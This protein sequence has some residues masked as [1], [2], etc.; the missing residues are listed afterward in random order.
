MSQPLYT[1]S[2]SALDIAAMDD[3][4]SP[5]SSTLSV[6]DSTNGTDMPM[7]DH[8]DDTS[9]FSSTDAT[10]NTNST[11][12]STAARLPAYREDSIRGSMS[13]TASRPML[14]PATERTLSM[15]SAADSV[16]S[17]DSAAS[18]SAASA[19][20]TAA[21]APPLQQ[22]KRR[23]KKSAAEKAEMEKNRESREGGDKDKDTSDGGD[24]SN[25][26]T[27]TNAAGKVI[28]RRAARACVS[29]RNRKVRCDVVETFPCGNCRWDKIECVVQEGRRRRRGLFN[30][31]ESAGP[32]PG[33]EAFQHH[34]VD[35]NGHGINSINS[36]NLNGLNGQFNSAFADPKSTLGQL[37]GSGVNGANGN[38]GANGTNGASFGFPAQQRI[39]NNPLLLPKATPG[40]NLDQSHSRSHNHNHSLNHNHHNHTHNGHDHTH[41]HNGHAHS[42]NGHN[43]STAA[44]PISIAAVASTPLN[45]PGFPLLPI[46]GQLGDPQQQVAAL[47]P[48]FIR[49]LPGKMAPEDI[50]YLHSKGA[51]TLPDITLQRALLHAYV[52]FVHPYMPLLELH[53]LLETIHDRDGKHG[54]IS[55][56]LYHAVMFAAASFV[57]AKFL[58]AA[59]FSRRREA[60][61][62]F[63]MKA[64]ALYDFDYETDRLTLVQA[65]LLMTYWY[66]TP[67]DQ[68]D[69]WHWMGVAVSLAHTIGLHRDPRTTG[70]P[71]RRQR[72]RKLLWWCCFMRDRMIA[73]GMRRP[74]RIRSEDADVPMLVPGDFDKAILPD[75]IDILPAECRL[76]R[77]LDMQQQLAELCV[78]KAKLCVLVGNML[79]QQ[80]TILPRGRQRGSDAGLGGSTNGA[81]GTSGSGSGSS[82][83]SS[84]SNNSTMMLFPNRPV[85]DDGKGNGPSVVDKIDAKL[86][87]WLLALPTSCRYAALTPSDVQNGRATIAVQRTLLHLVYHTTMSALHRP[88]IQPVAAGAPMLPIEQQEFSRARVR[89]AADCVTRMGGEMLRLRL[90]MYLPTAGVTV[91]LPAMFAHLLD[92]KGGVP[93]ERR[94]QAVLGFL[95]CM[96]VMES[97]RETYAAAEIAKGFVESLLKKA[98]ID[99]AAVTNFVE[100]NNITSSN[101]HGT[102][103]SSSSSHYSKM[104]MLD[105]S[106]TG[107]STPVNGT[108]ASLL[109]ATANVGVPYTEDGIAHAVAMYAANTPRATTPP[110]DDNRECSS[111]DDSSMNGLQHPSDH[112]SGTASGDI[113]LDLPAVADGGGGSSVPYIP[114]SMAA[115]VKLLAQRNNAAAANN[116]NNIGNIG[117]VGNVGHVGNANIPLTPL[118]ANAVAAAMATANTAVEQMWGLTPQGS[119]VSEDAFEWDATTAASGVGGLGATD[120]TGIKLDFDQWLDFPPEGMGSSTDHA[121]VGLFSSNFG[122]DMM[123]TE[124]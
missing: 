76:V 96:R 120:P 83:S 21:A 91:F 107:A 114:V 102:G 65:L 123:N 67:D 70:E 18:I 63:F 69:T 87:A 82:N 30:A 88:R 22:R 119:A 39:G 73:L 5:S 47:L 7:H 34:L 10:N 90:E 121:F 50:V 45:L 104:S 43:A 17:F 72:L 31:R 14:L 80:Y 13:S 52:E 112:G 89:D 115:A 71:V 25:N 53:P 93:R 44:D 41:N 15:S 118:S 78:E 37:N 97:L 20:S 9:P 36:I 95:T 40:V 68:K 55:L 32:L 42:H 98:G 122:N 35:A 48:G 1:L 11:N 85:S 2:P 94:Q 56:L 103:S 110:A 113:A 3:V 27:T 59:G 51:F 77:D 58:K 100:E 81:N 38:S 19:S 79:Q 60:R 74:K 12:S 57:P 106:G 33:A 99:L 46:N 66:E 54:T 23:T 117:N 101:I 108:S 116:A 105:G 49:P 4:S 8:D 111:A 28:K 75:E 109:Q 29:C 26:N 6:F 92:I 86:R 124:F 84:N 16:V 61:K 24:T 62:S 64:R